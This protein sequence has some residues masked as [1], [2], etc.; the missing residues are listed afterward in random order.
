[1]WMG[2][3]VNGYGQIHRDGRE[4][5]AHRAA[6]ERAF[7]ALSD[8]LCACHRCDNRLCVNPAH[9]F[10]GTRGDNNRDRAAKGRNGN[11]GAV[12]NS[13]KTHCKRGHAFDDANTDR[14]PCGRRA[15]RACRRE[16]VLQ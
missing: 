16:R 13:R 3:E 1:M 8:G 11:S 9:L 2:R 6:Y 12:Y 14:R 7:G 15:C 5:G 10:A 4:V